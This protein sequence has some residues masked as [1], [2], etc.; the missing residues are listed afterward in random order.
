MY[1]YDKKCAI[2]TTQKHSQRKEVY[3]MQSMELAILDWIQVNMRTPFLDKVVP[4][5]TRFNDNGELWIILAILLILFKK[6]RKA[7]LSVGVGLLFDLVSCNLILKPLIGRIRPFMVNTAIELLVEAPS[8]AAFPSGHTASSFAVVG[9]LWACK[10][11]LWKPVGIVALLI[12]LSRVY[13][14]VH[15]PTDILGGVI[16]GWF[17]GWLGAKLVML[18]TQWMKKRK[19]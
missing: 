18:V 4:V 7:G 10:S 13:L 5:F 17:C 19:Q 16:L 2:L 3:C 1:H 15:W 14:Y 11:P 6:H 9:A 8:S 12:A